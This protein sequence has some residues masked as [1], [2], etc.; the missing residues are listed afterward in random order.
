[1]RI[2]EINIPTGKRSKKCLGHYLVEDVAIH[3]ADSTPPSYE[4]A[5]AVVS[6]IEVAETETVEAYE[7]ILE[8][9]KRLR[10]EELKAEV[11]ASLSAEHRRVLGL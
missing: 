10:D 5:P 8:E 2:Y 11:L 3:I 7:A 6:A 4:G 1:M 9:Q